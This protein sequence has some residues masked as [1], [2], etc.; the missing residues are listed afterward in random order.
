MP[1][2]LKNSDFNKVLEEKIT[3]ISTLEVHCL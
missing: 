2:K 3:N 1:C